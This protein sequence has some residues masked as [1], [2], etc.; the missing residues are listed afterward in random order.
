MKNPTQ[1]LLVQIGRAMELLQAVQDDF[2]KNPNVLF[3]HDHETPG[4]RR[5]TPPDPEERQRI[6]HRAVDH[7]DSSGQAEQAMRGARDR[8]TDFYRSTQQDDKGKVVNNGL[9]N[10][11]NLKQAVRDM[12]DA[13]RGH[14]DGTN[15][16]VHEER[17]TDHT[18]RTTDFKVEVGCH[19]DVGTRS[20]DRCEITGKGEF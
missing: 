16:I 2:A 8:A 5:P 6:Y 4:D 19:V 12:I 14:M 9:Q 3:D 15:V 18:G 11:T 1:K 17:T 10:D 13:V 20:V 7:A